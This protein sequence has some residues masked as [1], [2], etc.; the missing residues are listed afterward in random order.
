MIPPASARPPPDGAELARRIAQGDS[1]AFE[2]LMRRHNRILYRLARS[3][4]KDDVEAEDALQEAYFSAFR[5]FESFRGDAALSTWLARI[6]VN[7][8]YGR[9]RKQKRDSTVVAFGANQR[10]VQPDGEGDMADETTGAPEAAAM[11]TQL[12][13][14]L[15]RRIDDLPEQF[16]TVF[17]LRDVQEMTVEETAACLDIPAATVRTRAFRARALLRESLARDIDV[18]TINAFGFDGERCDRVVAGVLDR[19]HSGT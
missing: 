11:R 13:E 19:L 15:E 12:R 4:L 18:A 2:P 14:L 3:I 8:A 17:M 6:V 10:D 9:L 5:H 7:E 1:S 16:R